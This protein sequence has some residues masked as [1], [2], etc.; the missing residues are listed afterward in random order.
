[1]RQIKWLVCC[2]CFAINALL[3]SF[4]RGRV[5]WRRSSDGLGCALGSCGRVGAATIRRALVAQ[6]WAGPVQEL[7]YTRGE[8]RGTFEEDGGRRLYARVKIAPGWKL[9]FSTITFRV[10]DPKL[11]TGIASGAVVEFRA[12]PVGGENTITALRVPNS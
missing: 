11:V 8:F 6:T 12:E 5:S 10:R 4:R 1:M 2:R 7:V 9:P 3:R